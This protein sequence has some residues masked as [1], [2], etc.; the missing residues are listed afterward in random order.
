MLTLHKATVETKTIIKWGSILA[1][2]IILLLILFNI[3]KSLKEYFFPTPPPPPTVSFGKLPAI[4][5]P[6]NATRQ[7]LTYT[8]NTLT[9]KL[10]VFPDR[11]K[12]FKMIPAKSS[13]SSLE[14][15]TTMVSQI[16]FT[17][18]PVSLSDTIYRWS[19]VNPPYKNITFDI[20]THG[21]TLF[22]DFLSTGSAI[23][24]A[25]N[26]GNE[27]NA[28]STSQNFLQS[29]SLFPSDID[30]NKTQTFLFSVTNSGLKPASSLSETQIIRVD[31]SQ[32]DIDSFPIYYPHPPYTTMNDL[33]GA[34]EDQSQV[35]EAHFFHQDVDQN[36]SA[37]YP[38]AS[39]SAALSDLKRGKGY[40]ASYYGNN[41]LISIKDIFLAYYMSDN[42]QSF[43]M[44]IIVFEGDNGFF[45]YVSAV[46]DAWIS[47]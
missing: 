15:A 36:T 32:K 19:D 41:A 23:F 7:T 33:V 38:I 6:L 28:I 26:L 16:G 1:G 39:A 35:V 27:N 30:I 8:I 22:S 25:H 11:M 40:I 3:T 2:S 18:N 37:T 13:L 17:Q 46:K 44:P 14:D 34:G 45:A 4:D 42:N 43:L 24:S 31:F 21:F 20:I 29:L 12:V 5:F 47:K 10:P 9:G